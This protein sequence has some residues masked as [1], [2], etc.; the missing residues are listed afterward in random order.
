M[1]CEHIFFDTTYAT[2]VCH[3]CGIEKTAPITPLN[4]Y[5]TNVPISTGYSRHHRMYILLKQLF[6][7]RFYGT[8]NS[9]VVAHALK[10]GP[11]VSGSELLHWLAKLKV[12]HKK[13]QNAHYYFARACPAYVIPNPPSQD[14]VLSIERAFFK[15]E[16]RFRG[17]G[18]N[19]K[20]FFSYN[21]LLRKLLVEFD[22][23]NYLPFVKTI[24][25]KKRMRMYETMWLFFM[26]LDNVATVKGVSQKIQR[27][28]VEPL[29]NVGRPLQVLQSVERLLIEN[30]LNNLVVAT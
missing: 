23:E 12:R 27:P 25:C 17:G 30:Y 19:Y 11:F 4:E 1:T 2:Q 26:N 18:H 5:T 7:P 28:P 3:R 24:K 10:H 22:L 16:Q 29:E 14:K 6:S 8:P 20:S 21:W 15:L 13:Y 9:T